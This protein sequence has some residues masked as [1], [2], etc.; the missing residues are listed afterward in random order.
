MIE[1]TPIE[2][3]ILV[4]RRKGLRQVDVA[5]KLGVPVR[6]LRAWEQGSNE[7]RPDGVEKIKRFV[8]RA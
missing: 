4:R 7:P 5:K 1:P 6:T 2:A 3:L 8:Q